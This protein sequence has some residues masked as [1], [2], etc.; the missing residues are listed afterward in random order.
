MQFLFPIS[1]GCFNFMAEL[2]EKKETK[3]HDI[4]P[5]LCK[6]PKGLEDFTTL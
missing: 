5:E 6:V 4:G 3:F 1:L 2:L